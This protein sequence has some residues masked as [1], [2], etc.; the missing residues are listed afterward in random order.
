MLLIFGL[1]VRMFYAHPAPPGFQTLVML[2]IGSFG[3]YE[4]WAYCHGRTTSIDHMTHEPRPENTI[5]RTLGLLG[6][7]FFV[8]VSLPFLY[9]LGDA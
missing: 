6:D 5:W 8:G 3:T 9:S 2:L 4:V 1:I 7:L